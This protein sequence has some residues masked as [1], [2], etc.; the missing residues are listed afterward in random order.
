MEDACD[1]IRLAFEQKCVLHLLHLAFLRSKSDTC[2]QNKS[3]LHMSPCITMSLGTFP[4]QAC[5]SDRHDTITRYSNAVKRQTQ[6]IKNLT[7]DS[8]HAM[9]LEWGAVRND[10]GRDAFLLCLCCSDVFVHSTLSL[11]LTPTC[12]HDCCPARAAKG[13]PSLVDA[14]K[15]TAK[16]LPVTSQDLVHFHG[17]KPHGEGALALLPAYCCA[18]CIGLR[19]AR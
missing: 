10:R 14:S 9:T 19:L 17:P 16:V 1:R 3:V 8:E 4:R 13:S 12:I 6:N 2:A 7:H 15:N 18:V 5:V 11:H